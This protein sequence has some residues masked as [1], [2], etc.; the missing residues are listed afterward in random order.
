M[1]MEK[2]Y[3]KNLLVLILLVLVGYTSIYAEDEKKSTIAVSAKILDVANQPVSNVL[4]S[5]FIGKDKVVTDSEGNFTI[6]VSELKTDHLYLEETGYKPMVVDVEKGELKEDHIV[7][8]KEYPIDGNRTLSF[9]YQDVPSSRSVSATTVVT[10]EELSTYPSSNFYE[11]LSGRVPDLKVATISA[12][13][14]VVN[15]T[16]RSTMGVPLN[17]LV[18]RGDEAVTYIDGVLRD[19]S[20]LSADEVEKVHVIRDLAGRAVLGLTGVAPVVWITTKKGASYKNQINATASVG[21]S[22]PTALPEYLDA[23]NY[24]TLYNEARVN[25]G[26]NPIYSQTALDAYKNNSDPVKFPN[27]D[28]QNEYVK[29]R[30]MFR[31]AN[32]NFSGGDEKVNYFSMVD[33]VGTDGLEAVGQ[34]SKLNRYKI[35]GNVH[36]KLNDWMKMNVNLSAVYGKRKFANSSGGAQQF[37]LF[38]YISQYP[39]NAHPISYDDKLIISNDYPMN[40]T[41]ELMYGGFAENIDLNSQNSAELII[42]LGS[43]LKGLSFKGSAAFDVNNSITNNKGGTAALYRLIDN[44]GE[45]GTERMVEESIIPNLSQSYDNYRRRTT[46]YGQFNYDRTFEK[47]AIIVN[48]S[49]N[50]LLEE[51]RNTSRGYQPLKKQDVGLRTN[52]AYDGKYVAELSLSYTGS[53]LLPK[54]NR[55]DLYSTLGAA[56]IMSKEDFLAD[57]KVIDYL[58][59]YGSYGSMGVDNSGLAGFNAYYLYQTLWQ[60]NGS[61]QSGVEGNKADPVNVYNI[62]Q[63]GSNNY[64]LPQVTD[65]NVGVQ[66]ELFDRRLSLE[67][68]Y[69]TR[70]GKDFLTLKFY[71]TPA[72]Y[73]GT[74]FL[75][76]SNFGENKSWGYDGNIQFTD[77]IGKLNYSFGVNASYKRSKIVKANEAVNLEDYQK[78]SGTQGDHFWGYSAEGLFQSDSEIQ[79][80]GIT[81]SW[82]DVQSG[83]IKYSDYNKDGVVDENDRHDLGEHTP[84]IYYGVNLSLEYKGVGLK[85]I[86]TGVA[87]GKRSNLYSNY[88]YNRNTNQN[89]SKPMLDR[90]PETNNYPR[91]TTT[92]LENNSQ[93][94][95]F[96]LTN[97]AYF[98][99]KNVE[100]SYTLPRQISRKF[101]MN[102]CKMFAQATNLFTASNLTKYGLNPENMEAGIYSYPMLKTITFGVAC[103]F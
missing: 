7:L 23:Y 73:G 61:W 89:Y 29:K 86:G 22:S 27:I 43:V 28:Y 46:A 48:A 42:D 36:I 101:L 35:R 83:D 71:D 53:M 100:L 97:A 81:Q 11:T 56:W 40:I 75:P 52:Y 77:K 9:P 26:L 47:H 64:K 96:W 20:D 67:L 6:Q 55:F 68:N 65:L 99:L 85:L 94:S 62:M 18:I 70:I 58:K 102:N 21:F 12:D 5:S 38:S 90:W 91:L 78:R 79:S 92:Q 4:I 17:I 63:A 103:K 76:A 45:I 87:D 80:R 30:V 84:R 33:Y 41:N 59:L 74:D 19:A 51:I 34:D 95:S 49:Y 98:T 57:S 82:G 32:V 31:K 44:N 69:F 14:Y 50:Q 37:N 24:A 15:G 2:K 66:S 93:S 39:S 1:I 10:G 88:F 16:I 3:I 72:I 25:D 60:A 13:Y 54:N 8:H